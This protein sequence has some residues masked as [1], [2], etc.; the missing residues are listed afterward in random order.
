VRVPPPPPPPGDLI[1]V[2]I[3]QQ[4]GG[5]AEEA[6][7][8]ANRILIQVPPPS[9]FPHLAPLPCNWLP[10]SASCGG[11]SMFAAEVPRQLAC[12]RHLQR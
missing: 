10:T 11:G 3:Q 7:R 4:A 5:S 8:T 2:A 9:P 1:D 6:R 12:R